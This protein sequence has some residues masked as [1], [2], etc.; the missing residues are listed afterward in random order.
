MKWRARLRQQWKQPNGVH[1]TL[2]ISH[3]ATK[4]VAKLISHAV[5]WWIIAGCLLV[6]GRWRHLKTTWTLVD[7]WKASETSHSKSSLGN[8]Q[9]QYLVELLVNAY[10][11]SLMVN[12]VSRCCVHGS[13]LYSNPVTISNDKCLATWRRLG[14]VRLVDNCSECS[15]NSFGIK[16]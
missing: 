12:S 13:W 16:I 11:Y 14:N 8:F 9:Y 4:S 2:Q 7:V 15:V 3:K 6:K 1:F 10:S 5:I